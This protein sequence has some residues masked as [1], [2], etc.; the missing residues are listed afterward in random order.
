[1]H[2]F[3]YDGSFAGFLSTVFDSYE[4][5][6]KICKI[7]KKDAYQPDAFSNVTE[8]I[9]DDAKAERVWKS[10]RN[11]ISKGAL[12]NLFS[13]YLS[14]EAGI[15]QAMFLYIQSIFSSPENIEKDFGNDA[16]LKVAQTSKKVFREKH[17]FEA[18]IRFQL[19]KDGLYFAPAEPDFNILPLIIP[20]F[21][22]RFKDQRWLIYDVKRKYGIYFDLLNV[23]SVS[24]NP[25]ENPTSNPLVNPASG[26]IQEKLLHPDEKSF[27]VLW[28]EYFKSSNISSRKNL[29]LHIQHMP[30][31]YWKY[32][33]EKH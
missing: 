6:I 19:L 4:K 31:R 24:L 17:R 27:Q 15:E 30:H 29:K 20:H 32:L 10:L 2:I 5:K 3:I 22:A 8:V 21:K 11:K 7:F 12:Y 1:M 14:E 23:S 25:L 18:F 9:S 33:T 26:Y 16:V 28:K 13:C